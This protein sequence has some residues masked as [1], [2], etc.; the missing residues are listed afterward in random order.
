[1]TVL[2]QNS[3]AYNEELINIFTGQ[4][5]GASSF[6][7]PN[8]GNQYSVTTVVITGQKIGSPTG[9]T[10]MRLWAHTG[11]FGSTA[12]PTGSSLV[13]SDAIDISTISTSIGDITF[14][15]ST[16]FTLS[17]NTPYFWAVEYTGGNGSNYL[18]VRGHTGQNSTVGNAAYSTDTGSTWVGFSGYSTP[19]TVN[20]T[21]VAAGPAN[22]KT[23]DGITQST[24]I[25]TYMGVVIASV[26][27]VE[28]VT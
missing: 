13:T 17:I 9:N 28:G 18:N 2:F 1:M 10:V 26:K 6:K 12:T 19:T 14:T 11:T 23:K 24:G 16:P 3:D 20:G 25:K 7:T 15:F 21:A 4:D 8:D 22:V 27:S 5:E